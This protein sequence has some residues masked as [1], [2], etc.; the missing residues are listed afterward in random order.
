MDRD[1]W[2]HSDGCVICPRCNKFIPCDNDL[3]SIL[4]AI[5]GH[6]CETDPGTGLYLRPPE[7]PAEGWYWAEPDGSYR[8]TTGR[9][10]R[11]VS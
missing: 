1:R 5:P 9:F 2:V 6:S 7:V 8:E 11:P 10:G 3:A 4:T